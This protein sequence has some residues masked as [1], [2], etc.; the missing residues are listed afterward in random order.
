M[1]VKLTVDGQVVETKADELLIDLLLRREA[2]FRVSAIISSLVPSRRA[3][4]A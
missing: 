3:T 4:L 2:R 1:I